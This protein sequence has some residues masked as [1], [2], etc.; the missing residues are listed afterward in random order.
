MNNNITW[1]KGLVTHN[2]RRR[3][4]GQKP[5]VIWFTG[6]SGSG[7]SAV[8]V[9]LEARLTADGYAAYLLD[10]D[11]LRS[12]INCGLGFSEED[13]RENVRRIAET[14]RL[15]ADSGQIAIVSAISPLRSMRD[16][17]RS[18]ISDICDFIEIFVDTPLEVCV[19]RDV[20]GLYQRAIAGEIKEFTGISS[21]YEPPTD[22]DIT[23]TDTVSLSAAE[24]LSNP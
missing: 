2:D 19:Q 10:G 16:A 21:P 1:Q 17:A 4:T 12:G 8:A 18:R 7:K 9:E 20:K 15:I 3:I 11:N 6:L 13:R 24:R 14:A 23:I 5:V 22:P